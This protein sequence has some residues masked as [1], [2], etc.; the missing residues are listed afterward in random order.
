MKAGGVA[1]SDAATRPRAGAARSL[2]TSA[3]LQRCLLRSAAL[4]ALLF[5][6]VARGE[7]RWTSVRVDADLL[8]DGTVEVT[9]KHVLVAS[10]ESFAATRWLDVRRPGVPELVE[11]VRVE[12]DGRETKLEAGS[13]WEPDR[14]EW[15]GTVLRWALKPGNASPWEAPTTLFYRLKWKLHGALTP[16]WGPRSA[17]R[18]MPGSPLGE[19]LAARGRETREALARAGERPLH[20]YVLDLNVAAPG[21]EGPIETLDYGLAGDDAWSFGGNFMSVTLD[22]ALPGDEG[23]DLSFLFDRKAGDRPAGVDVGSPAALVG[24]ALV[25]AAAG[26][27]LLARTLLAW[28]R[29]RPR[30]SPAPAA[31]LPDRPEALSPEVFGA[32][33]Q[34]VPPAEPEL[35][36]VWVRLRDEKVVVLDRQE[37]PNLVLRRDA[38]ELRPPEASFARLLFGERSALPLAEA[39]STIAAL[40]ERL[41]EAVAQAY[42]EEVLHRIGEAGPRTTEPSERPR[43]VSELSPTLVVALLLPFALIHAA[44]AEKAVA[45]A[46]ALAASAVLFLAAR[47]ARARL[48]A[49]STFVAAAGAVLVSAVFLCVTYLHGGPPD[50]L[51]SALLAVVALFVVRAGFVGAR[52]ASRKQASPL[53]A[54]ALEQREA[55]RERLLRSGGEVEPAEAP[56]FRAAGLE[57]SLSEPGVSRDEFEE[58]LGAFSTIPPPD[59]PKG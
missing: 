20:R 31:P 46:G 47:K 45:I 32:L 14:Y 55:L 35:R 15:D 11:V 28:Q 34:A 44:T 59:E 2:L 7:L 21:R 58:L 40:G 6:P 43:D 12:S 9:E 10:G 48:G 23:I 51:R 41:D 53:H 5:A 57:V 25:P 8:A 56:W 17:A 37:P 13:L 36:E 42:D 38:S 16:V 33:F 52:P 27:W 54:W 49:G 19:R 4:A 22:R 30:R 39:R 18:P 29:R 50:V 3:I 24:L 26:A 1:P